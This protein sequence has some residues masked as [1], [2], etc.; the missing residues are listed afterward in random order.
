[1]PCSSQSMDLSDFP[2][3]PGIF[4]CNAIYNNYDHLL[5]RAMENNVPEK[6]IASF[7]WIL[8]FIWKARNEKVFSNKEIQ[9]EASL[10][11]ALAESESWVFAQLI[12]NSNAEQNPLTSTSTHS[13]QARTLPSCQ[14]DASWM[15]GDQVWG[16]GLVIDTADGNH[17]YGATAGT[18]VLSPLHA[19]FEA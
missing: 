11:S 13:E 16:G 5:W 14:V 10:Q 1:M 15:S 9:P 19:E 3:T 8:W 7:P 12:D 2:T 17:V 4:P 6:T 18:Q